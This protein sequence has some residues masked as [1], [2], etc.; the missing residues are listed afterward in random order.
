MAFYALSVCAVKIIEERCSMRKSQLTTDEIFSRWI[1]GELRL[2]NSN[3]NRSGCLL[4][5]IVTTLCIE[6]KK[7]GYRLKLKIIYQGE[8]AETLF[9]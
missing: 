9:L 6:E 2:E 3:N 4:L 1:E 8:I 5:S 7:T